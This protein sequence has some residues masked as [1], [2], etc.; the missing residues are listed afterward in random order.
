MHRDTNFTCAKVC[1]HEEMPRLMAS[2]P[3]GESGA[4]SFGSSRGHTARGQV[5]GYQK[6]CFEDAGQ[7]DLD[8][9]LHLQ[10]ASW[11]GE[12]G[13]PCCRLGWF[14]RD[15][16]FEMVVTARSEAAT[17]KPDCQLRSGWHTFRRGRVGD[18]EATE[19][20]WSPFFTRPRAMLCD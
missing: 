11:E 12:P 4:V 10:I 17:T 13:K 9:L 15:K 6:I 2:T 19:D 1:L 18:G 7:I 16:T 5:I 14:W 20:G 3:G 8:A